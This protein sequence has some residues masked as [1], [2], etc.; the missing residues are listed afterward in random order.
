MRSL[1]LPLGLA[2]A[3][4]LVT[5]ARAADVRRVAGQLLAGKGVAFAVVGDLASVRAGLEGLG[6]GA[7]RL[8]DADGLA[9]P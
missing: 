4:S 3:L 6:L 8:F 7:P 9:T 5:P 2:A 1:A